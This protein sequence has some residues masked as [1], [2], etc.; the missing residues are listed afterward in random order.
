MSREQ[1]LKD[2]NDCLDKLRAEDPKLDV[3]LVPEPGSSGWTDALEISREHPIV[4]MV[5]DATKRVIGRECQIGGFTGGTDAKHFMS[6]AGT[7]TVS[8]FG[9]GLLNLAHGPNER[10]PIEDL[11]NASKI[12]AIT[13]LRYLQ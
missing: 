6:I 11:I 1:V 12:Y 2:L 9:P 5:V 13:A 8:A 10:V 4:D 3:E 7:P